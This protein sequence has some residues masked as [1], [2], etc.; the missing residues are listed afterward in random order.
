MTLTGEPHRIARYSEELADS[1]Y[2]GVDFL[3]KPYSADQVARV[4][5]RSMRRD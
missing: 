2:E 1:A 3:A 4:L 5:A